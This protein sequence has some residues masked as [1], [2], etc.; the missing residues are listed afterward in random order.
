VL[1]ATTLGAAPTVV[2]VIFTL[3][4]LTLSQ[5]PTLHTAVYSVVVEGLTMIELPVMP[6]DQIIVPWQVLFVVSVVL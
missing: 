1:E 3:F 5:V 6:L 4:E 2:T